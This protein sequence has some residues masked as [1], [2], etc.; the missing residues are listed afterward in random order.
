MRLTGLL[1]WID[2]WRKSSAFMDMTLEEQGAY[3][4][5]LD[6]AHLRGGPL[7]NDERIL[8]KACGDSTAWTR[9]RRT[10][11]ARFDLQA[12]GFHNITLDKIL[13]ES[14]RRAQKQA[15]YRERR[16]GHGN[17]HGNVVGIAAGNKRGNRLGSP[18]PDPD[19]DLG[20]VSGAGTRKKQRASSH[21]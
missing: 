5:L 12:D 15:D 9:V 17:G 2:R 20:T 6:E 3:R 7:P 1:W 10:V 4:N 18:D 19:P 16:N 13:K 21:N 14:V 8:A 11:L